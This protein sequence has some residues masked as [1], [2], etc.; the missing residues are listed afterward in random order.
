MLVGCYVGA[1]CY[2]I[3]Y[4]FYDFTISGLLGKCISEIGKATYHILYVQMLFYVVYYDV[5]RNYFVE[6]FEG[7]ICFVTA[8]VCILFVGIVWKKVEHRL[9]KDWTIK[10]H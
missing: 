3:I 4:R 10:K 5:G 8:A 7:K 6:G 9:I 1:V 2:I